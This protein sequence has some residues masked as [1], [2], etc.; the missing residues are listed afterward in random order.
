MSRITTLLLRLR[1]SRSARGT[2]YRLYRRPARWL[3]PAG[4]RKDRSCVGGP[5]T[6]TTAI[7]SQSMCALANSAECLVRTPRQFGLPDRMRIH[8]PN[9]AA[10]R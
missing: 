10:I 9:A 3:A 6:V 7:L 2:Q 8:G 4:S 5:F 1:E